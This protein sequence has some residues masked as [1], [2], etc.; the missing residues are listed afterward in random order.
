MQK[1]QNTYIAKPHNSSQ[2]KGITVTSS[3]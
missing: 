2:G 3:L 1:F